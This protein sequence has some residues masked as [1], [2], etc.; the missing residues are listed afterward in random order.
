MPFALLSG[1]AC[2]SIEIPLPSLTG[3]P[4]LEEARAAG[5]PDTP[6]PEMLAYSDAQAIRRSSVG[7][8]AAE[9][10]G[11]ITWTNPET[12]AFGTLTPLG[13]LERDGPRTCQRFSASV[14]SASG[15]F[16]YFAR[17][18]RDAT[19]DVRLAAIGDTA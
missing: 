12:E 6:L 19:G 9:G 3:E 13:P 11:P 8:F 1:A 4:A 2:A 17:S 15:V 5:L 18:C 16:R 14:N 10:A 7:L